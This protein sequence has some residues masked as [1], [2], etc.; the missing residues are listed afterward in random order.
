MRALQKI[1]GVGT[2]MMVWRKVRVGLDHPSGSWF[3]RRF[4][5]S[6]TV[7]VDRWGPRW[8]RLRVGTRAPIGAWLLLAL[9]IGVPV[10][11]LRKLW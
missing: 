1:S 9:W 7:V 3:G 8:A 2:A 10:L 4:I 11:L 5:E 6:A